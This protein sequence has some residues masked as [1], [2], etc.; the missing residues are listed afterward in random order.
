VKK[1]TVT[2]LPG[3]LIG[4]DLAQPVIDL[5]AAAGAELEWEVIEGTLGT[6]DDPVREEVLASVRRNGVAL[7][8][9][10]M[11]P[12]GVGNLSPSVAL[13]KALDLYAGIRPVKKTPCWPLPL[14][15]S[16]ICAL[17]GKQRRNCS[18]ITPLLASAA[19]LS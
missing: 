5:L 4:Q 7:K 13:R 10:F 19:L 6:P 3:D 11:T 16:R 18:K 8:G 2:L 17:D 1:R 14:P 9:P 15:I 12:K